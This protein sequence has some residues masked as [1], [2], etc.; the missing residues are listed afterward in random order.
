M[1]GIHD[2][3]ESES[4]DEEDEQ[5]NILKDTIKKHQFDYN[6]NTNMT[7]NYP[8][9][10]LDENGRIPKINEELLFAPAER[11]YPVNLLTEKDW[12]IKS[13]PTS[14]QM[15]NMEFTKKEK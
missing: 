5:N 2:N 1:T 4:D 8:E 12:D 7:S 3:E 9:M 13:W 15:G 14:I 11:N 10:F 6:R